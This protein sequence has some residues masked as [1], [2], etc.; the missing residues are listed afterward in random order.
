MSNFESPISVLK[1][2]L[3][4]ICIGLFL[5]AILSYVYLLHHEV[6]RM[7]SELNTSL[8]IKA[9]NDLIEAIPSIMEACIIGPFLGLSGLLFYGSAYIMFPV[10][11]LF[12]I[13]F[14][15]VGL[16]FR[17]RK[18]AQAFGV[19]SVI[20]YIIASILGFPPA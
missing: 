20:F 18:W 17:G 11:F 16:K 15:F 14:F 1:Y 12:S 6:V 7:D 9:L 8:A 5:F 19:L 10:L 3:I 4:S 13:S 2:T